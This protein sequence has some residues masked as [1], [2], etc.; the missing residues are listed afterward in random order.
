MM[1]KLKT[2]GPIHDTLTGYDF[3]EDKPLM[4]SKA[5]RAK[6]VECCAG[7]LAEVRRCKLYD[8]PLWP[9]RL[10][11]KLRKD[12]KTLARANSEATVRR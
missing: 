10:G 5:I 3:R 2:K 1:K 11:R 8:C 7:S 6:C 9:W 4:R 12:E